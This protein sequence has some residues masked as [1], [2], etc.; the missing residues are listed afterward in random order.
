MK[1]LTHQGR[2]DLVKRRLWGRNYKVEDY[3]HMTMIDFD[4]LVQGKYTVLVG[5][6]I[7]KGTHLGHCHVFVEVDA[8][9]K[10]TYIKLG[11][12]RERHKSPT[13]VFG[14]DNR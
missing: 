9:G 1:K 2:I 4:L 10:I 7:L 13:V 12:Q 14:K 8:Q 5:A 6:K 11:H 3:S